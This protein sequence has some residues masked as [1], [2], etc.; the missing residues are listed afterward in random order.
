MT[1]VIRTLPSGEIEIQD[2][3]GAVTLRLPPG[4]DVQAALDD[5]PKPPVPAIR[6]ITLVA[7]LNRATDAEKAAVASNSVLLMALVEKVAEGGVPS[8]N[9][10]SSRVAGLLQTAGMQAA[11]IAAM[12]SDGDAAEAA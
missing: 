2:E 4:A 8:V 10:D 3:N 6:V 9:L 11:R 7:F 5:L 1:T 12:M